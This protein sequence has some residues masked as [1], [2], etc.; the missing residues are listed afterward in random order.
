MCG[1]MVQRSAPRHGIVHINFKHP[2]QSQSDNLKDSE[3]R[4]RLAYFDA[5]TLPPGVHGVRKGEAN[6]FQ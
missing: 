3:D 5:A 1:E 2:P 4:E 6:A